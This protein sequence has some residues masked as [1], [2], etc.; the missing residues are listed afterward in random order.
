ML[1]RK[2]NSL[3]ILHCKLYT[4]ETIKLYQNITKIW[5]GYKNGHN[6]NIGS[7]LLPFNNK[8]ISM[9]NSTKI[10]KEILVIPNL[11]NDLTNYI[12]SILKN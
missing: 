4:A 9:A 7:L 5:K 6:I 10:W 8:N 3:P 2:C 1:Q 12:T 11:H